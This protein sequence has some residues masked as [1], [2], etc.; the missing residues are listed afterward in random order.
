MQDMTSNQPYLLRAFYD[1]ILDN[2]LTPY[3]AIDTSFPEV[4]V[5][6]QF[7]QNDQIVL[8]VAP[9]ACSNFAM[10]LDYVQF[11]ARFAGQS[12]QVSFPVHAITA[13]YA[14]E[15]GAG[16]MFTVPEDLKEKLLEQQNE[17][18]S[19]KGV[20]PQKSA[21]TNTNDSEADAESKKTKPKPGLRIVK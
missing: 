13:I 7:V 8:N 5:P 14:K 10:D 2:N 20:T 21:S 1:W 18:A 4:V 17:T 9:A 3:L 16:T 15:N 12:M 11:Q 6:T 19:L